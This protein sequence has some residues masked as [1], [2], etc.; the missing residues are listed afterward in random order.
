[1]NDDL[2]AIT[3]L[4]G[5]NFRLGANL[6]GTAASEIGLVNATLADNGAAGREVGSGNEPD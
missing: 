4:G 2:L 1:V 3:L 5:L 6:D